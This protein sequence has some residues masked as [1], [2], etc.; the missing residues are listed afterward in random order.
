[1]LRAAAAVGLDVL[2]KV[3]FAIVIGKLLP[4]F[5]ALDGVNEDMT[6]LNLGLAVG[7]A[8]MVDIAS[9][10]RARGTIYRL[11]FVHLEEIFTAT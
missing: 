11:A 6:A 2:V 3:F 7:A 9:D 10:V 4:R 1:M 5:D 8:R